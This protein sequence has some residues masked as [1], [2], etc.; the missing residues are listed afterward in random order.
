MQVFASPP[1]I[2]LKASYDIRNLSGGE[3]KNQPRGHI[4]TGGTLKKSLRDTP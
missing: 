1:T 4:Q 3:A 2:F